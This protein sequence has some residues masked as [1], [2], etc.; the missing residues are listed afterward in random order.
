MSSLEEDYALELDDLRKA[1]AVREA[2]LKE[3]GELLRSL[4]RLTKAASDPAVLRRLTRWADEYPEYREPIV[5][6]LREALLEAHAILDQV[7]KLT[8][9]R[10]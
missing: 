5:T 10:M 9:I 2:R 7:I 6:D 8:E 1:L 3:F 4:K